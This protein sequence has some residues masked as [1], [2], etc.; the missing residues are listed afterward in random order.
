MK[1]LKGFFPGLLSLALLIGYG[2]ASDDDGQGDMI[3]D[4]LDTPPAGI[5]DLQEMV[6]SMRP[7]PATGKMGK[8]RQ[9]IPMAG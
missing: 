1:F 6:E 7:E 2:C 8:C 9:Q 4:P 3:P 5:V